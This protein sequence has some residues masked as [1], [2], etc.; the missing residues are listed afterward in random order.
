[1]SRMSRFAPLLLALAACGSVQPGY[2]TQPIASAG[3]VDPKK[4]AA[5][6]AGLGIKSDAGVAPKIKRAK[7]SDKEFEIHELT[8]NPR[9]SA[10][11][12]NLVRYMLHPE[13]WILTKLTYHSNGTRTY[14]FR[15]IVTKG[16]RVEVDPLKPPAKQDKKDPL[17][18][19][20][21]EKEANPDDPKHP[22]DPKKDKP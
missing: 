17:I 1:M 20:P 8:V 19:K 21:P 18:K 12:F 4:Q 9:K 15:R 13:D 11:N 3:A 14:V 5:D 22:F 7:E 6:L 2:D 16:P 10:D